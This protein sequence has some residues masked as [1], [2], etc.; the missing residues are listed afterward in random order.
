MR[1]ATI[2]VRDAPEQVSRWKKG[3]IEFKNFIPVIVCFAI[4]S[5]PAQNGKVE[6]PVSSVAN[7]PSSQMSIQMY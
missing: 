6:P 2:R 7:P 1:P 4:W 3:E 5:P